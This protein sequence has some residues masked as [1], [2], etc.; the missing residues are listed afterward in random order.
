MA[1]ANV[2]KVFALALAASPGAWED[3][4]PEKKRQH[5]PLESLWIKVN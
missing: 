2:E 1:A 5:A 4:V 3:L